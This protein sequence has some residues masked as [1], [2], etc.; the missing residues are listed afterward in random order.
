MKYRFSFEICNLPRITEF[1]LKLHINSQSLRQLESNN[2][3]QCVIKFWNSQ[4]AIRL[5]IRN[6]FLWEKKYRLLTLPVRREDD[7]NK[8]SVES[9]KQSS[10]PQNVG[11]VRG[12]LKNCLKP[13]ILSRFFCKIFLKTP[14][15]KSVVMET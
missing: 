9:Y 13:V 7:I 8:K 5:S 14:S 11:R 10:C 1:A 6:F 3:P 15:N 4:N 2:F 12:K